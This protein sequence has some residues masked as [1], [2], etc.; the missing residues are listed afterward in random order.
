M[1]PN[2]NFPEPIQ[3]NLK[4]DPSQALLATFP[5]RSEN[6]PSRAKKLSA[7]THC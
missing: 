4:E 5:S 2:R 1:G 6:A 7:P 3:A